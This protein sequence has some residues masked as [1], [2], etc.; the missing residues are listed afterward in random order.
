MSEQN[1]TVYALGPE[2]GVYVCLDP[3]W[4]LGWS[5]C[6]N[7]H[8]MDVKRLECCQDE[9]ANVMLF[10]LSWI[11]DLLLASSKLGV[12]ETKQNQRSITMD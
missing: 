10:A 9:S 1:W 6:L 12:L 3:R 4:P 8:C 5:S 2:S 7:G 11:N